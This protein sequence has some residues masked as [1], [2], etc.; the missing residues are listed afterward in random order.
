MADFSYLDQFLDMEI[1]LT[2]YL[3]S[4]PTTG[5]KYILSN[6]QPVITTVK[7]LFTK[8]DIVYNYKNNIN[9]I[10]TYTINDG[11]FIE[12]VSHKIYGNVQYW[13]VIA[14]FNDIKEPFKDWPL[15]QE[16]VITISKYLF[17]NEK[18][19]SYTTYLNFIFE[20]NETK[21]KI[22]VPN[23]DTLK[24]IIWQFRQAILGN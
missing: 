4:I 1:D 19:Y 21:R 9:A 8:F 11:D 22:I 20:K 16:Q 10:T 18:K 6:K 24:E 5:E 2:G 15:S 12:A 7:N 3:L 13:W 14:I 17:D 23:I